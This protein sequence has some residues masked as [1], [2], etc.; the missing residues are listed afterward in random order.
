MSLKVKVLCV[1]FAILGGVYGAWSFKAMQAIQ[2]I[3]TNVEKLQQELVAQGG[4]VT[5]RYDSLDVG[6]FTK[7]PVISMVNPCVEYKQPVRRAMLLC[8]KKL[9]IETQD[10]DLST[11]R[12]TLPLRG[13]AEEVVA[14]V[15]TQY[16]I[17]ADNAPIL[18]LRLPKAEAQDAGL[19]AAF[20]GMM[21]HKSGAQ[22]A[23]LPQDILHQWALRLPEHVSLRVA[24]AGK[25]KQTDFNFPNVPMLLWRPVRYDISYPLDIF[26]SLLAEIRA[27]GHASP[28]IIVP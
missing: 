27:N 26:F 25:A 20:K 18:A 9:K 4:W 14:G 11:Y 5:L 22:L 1:V 12:M 10:Y 2:I 21:K 15:K 6:G 8:A 7:P 19:P 28:P 24:V 3:Q 13:T 17:A 23:A 16:E